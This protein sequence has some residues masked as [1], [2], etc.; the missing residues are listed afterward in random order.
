MNE[1]ALIEKMLAQ[2]RHWVEVAPGKEIQYR[3]PDETEVA[4]MLED[5][6]V[7]I[8]VRHVRKFVVGWKGITEADLLGEGI[9]ASDEVPFSSRVWD[10]LVSDRIAW[11]QAV[12]VAILE[13]LSKHRFSIQAEAKNS[14]PSST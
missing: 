7:A 14:E 1:A 5:G 11:V 6:K 12:A 2:R 13:T 10:L 3:R 9:G 8:D 4:S